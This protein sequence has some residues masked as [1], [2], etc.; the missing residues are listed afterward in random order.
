MPISAL[1]RFELLTSFNLF[2]LCTLLMEQLGDNIILTILM[3]T[4]DI[5]RFVLLKY[6][7][8]GVTCTFRLLLV[9]LL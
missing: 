3:L 2:P 9:E 4:F 1:K 6:F 8:I 5:L 7:A